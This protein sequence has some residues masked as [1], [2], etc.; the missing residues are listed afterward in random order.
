MSVSVLILT[1]NEA[2]N[3]PRCLAALAGC[4]DVVVLDSF[5]TDATTRVAEAHGARVVQ[6]TFDDFAG[7]R[8][9]G[10]TQIDW[11]HEWVLHLDADEVITPALWAEIQQAV[12]NTQYQAFYIPAKTMFHGQ[13]LKHAGLYPSYQVRLTRLPAF[14]FKMV[15]HGQ[16]AAIDDA[17]IGVLE[18]AY[19]HYSFS[20]GLT[21]WFAKH[22]G[23]ATAEAQASLQ[24]QRPVN[25]RDLLSRQALRRR[26][27]LRY[28]VFRLPCRPLL[29]FCY[30][31]VLRG[32]FLDGRAGWAYCRLLM[33]YELMIVAKIA[34]Y[35]QGDDG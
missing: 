29:R 6:R 17:D 21:A 15:G 11:R 18:Q 31:Y 34:A 24:L 28:L 26:T 19:E 12:D 8:N 22:N 30:M 4:D 1:L 33:I 10:L 35:K 9:Y 32:G 13:W 16:K 3:L 23:Y 14:R 7:Q 2:D 5:S 20:K 27:A 25:W